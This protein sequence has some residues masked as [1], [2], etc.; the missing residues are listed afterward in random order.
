MT[1]SAHWRDAVSPRC[2][3]LARIALLLSL[4]SVL[5]PA[6]RAG[7]QQRPARD[8]TVADSTARDSLAARLERAEAAIAL[9]R[10]QLAVEAGSVVRTRS[11][12]QLELTARIV[13]NAFYSSQRVNSVDVPQ[14]ALAPLAAAPGATP[15]TRDL[16]MS[17]RQSRIG[18][19]VTVDSVMGGTFEGDFELDFFG[20]VS[21]GPGDRRLYPEP[22]M[23]V[24]RAQM[25]WARTTVFVGSET[26][27]I[28][29]LNPVSLA[30]AAVPGFITAGNL[31]NWLPQLRV[32]RDVYRN[33]NGV[34]IGVQGA[35]LSPFT[36]VQH[37]AETDAADAG[38]RSARPFVEGRVHVRWGEGG[39]QTGA[40][41]DVQLGARGGEVGVGVHRGWVRVTGDTNTASKAVSLDARYAPVSWF[42]VRGEAYTGQLVRGLGGGAV[43][44]SFGRALPGDALGAPLRDEAGWAQA[45]V[46]A[47]P[48]LIVGAGCG[49]NRVRRSDL[50]QRLAN[51]VCSTHLL[52]RVA[53]PLILGLEFR[54]MRTRYEEGTSRANH[55]NLT[56]GFEL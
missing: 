35:L 5:W 40:P 37:V 52:W 27:L 45:N 56:F 55:V 19:A 31:W 2:L 23:R 48:T 3:S 25:H 6:P 7:A 36:G 20:G 49:R 16:G 39:E 50:P 30:T 47:H 24:V 1:H 43:G 17:V 8:T 21:N 11:R 14:F 12:L 53:Q 54:R 42:E 51:T 41:S 38:E 13:T 18:A 10:Q 4:A 22:R 32:S 29:D 44:Q 46:Q 15:G 26:P 9:L 33:A 28:S 34:R